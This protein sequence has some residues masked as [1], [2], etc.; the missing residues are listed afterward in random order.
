MNIN[1]FLTAKTIKM[2][3]CY[4]YWTAKI[5]AETDIDCVLI[6]DSAS[7]VMHGFESTVSAD[8][9]MMV[10]HTRAVKRGIKDKFL[11]GDMPFLS[12]RKSLAETMD[13]VEKLMKAGAHSIKLEGLVGNEELIKHIIAS[14]VP[15]MGHLGFTPQSTNLFGKSIVQGKDTQSA[16]LLIE[17]AK[18]LED[19]GC[20]SIVLECI[21]EDLS[22]QI[23]DLL[24]IPTIGIGAG[25]HTSG[26]VLV[27][28]ALLGC[29]PDF[30]PKFLKKYLNIHGLIKDAVNHYCR[31][32]ETGAFPTINHSY[33]SKTKCN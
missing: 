11:I 19:L 25:P 3:T 24:S 26:Q 17:S 29:N 10:A 9:E 1:D 30:N 28:Q 16:Q 32:V 23:T 7:M 33:V 13:A 5:I 12:Y 31:E 14:G 20:F 6:G 2:I 8:I 4:D 18:A 21:P 15:V 22:K 27:L